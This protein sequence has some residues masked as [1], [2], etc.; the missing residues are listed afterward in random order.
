[1]FVVEWDVPDLHRPPS[2]V[3]K[4]AGGY[5]LGFLPV[6][7]VS[8]IVRL[9]PELRKTSAVVFQGPHGRIKNVL[10]KLSDA[11][12]LALLEL[13]QL[14]LEESLLPS[15]S[16]GTH[17]I[18]M[19]MKLVR[20][21]C[22]DHLICMSSSLHSTQGSLDVL[23][24][25]ATAVSSELSEQAIKADLVLIQPWS[26]ALPS[27]YVAT[28]STP[29]AGNGLFA[30]SAM[31]R[32]T[33]IGVYTGRVRWRTRASLPLHQRRYTF[34]AD[35][36]ARLVTLAEAGTHMLTFINEPCMGEQANVRAQYVRVPVDG[37]QVYLTVNTL[38]C[39][40]KAG[41]ELYLHYGERCYLRD[42][43]VGSDAPS[44]TQLDED[45]LLDQ[46]VE[47][48]NTMGLQACQVA[49]TYGVLELSE[50][51]WDRDAKNMMGRLMGNNK[52]AMCSS[53]LLCVPPPL[54]PCAVSHRLGP[55]IPWQEPGS[56]M[57]SSTI[58]LCDV[59]QQAGHNRMVKATIRSLNST[60][61]GVGDA[62][63][64]AV[65]HKIFCADRRLVHVS[66]FPANVSVMSPLVEV[67]M[68]RS[69][70]LSGKWS[71]EMGP[72]LTNTEHGSQAGVQHAPCWSEVSDAWL[73]HSENKQMRLLLH[74]HVVVQDLSM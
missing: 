9:P 40:V 52:A 37:W 3:V 58:N 27:L 60:Y 18:N 33:I 34:T 49:L 45:V 25:V 6:L 31:S 70:L 7:F 46:F 1:M 17:E 55:F 59:E 10:S 26:V 39:D 5:V 16:W 43:L 21:T 14:R 36:S 12:S 19:A 38:V 61:R 71:V 8:D 56:L 28:S 11:D 15:K 72:L 62:D 69:L 68:L 41:E 64:V 42:Y 24:S 4:A 50:Q 66:N 32:G 35:P 13:I 74:A 53:S 54:T 63:V 73:V 29:T 48:C 44:C 51:F 67:E 47:F 2:V 65:L 57:V 23:A 22:V 30:S 20:R